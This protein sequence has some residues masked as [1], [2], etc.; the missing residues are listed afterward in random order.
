MA[1]IP[2]KISLILKKYLNVLHNNSIPVETMI[3]FGS[4]AKGTFHEWSDI[5]LAIVS[6]IFEGERIKDKNKIRRLTLSVSSDLEIFPYNPHNFIDE[7][8]LVYEILSTGIK[9]F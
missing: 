5:D 6:T 2:H 3:L 1:K 9:V 7:D 4:Y 8:P